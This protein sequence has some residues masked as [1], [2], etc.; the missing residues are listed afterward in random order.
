MPPR[1][2]IPS[3]SRS[4]N[5]P[6]CSW[7][8]G[9]ALGPS[10]YSRSASS[11]KKRS[12]KHHDPFALALARQRKAANVSRQQVLQEEREAALGDSVRGKPTPFT[13][14]LLNGQ[15]I[16]RITPAEPSENTSQSPGLNYF[17]S[18]D[19]LNATLERSEKLSRPVADTKSGSFDPQKLEDET[20]KHLDKH[21][22]AQEAVKRIMDLSN[23]SS[24]ERKLVNIQRCIETFG[25][26][27]TDTALAP[28]PTGAAN[29][30]ASQLPLSQPPCWSRYR[31]VGSSDRDFNYKDSDPG[32][33]SRKDVTQ[34]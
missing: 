33:E 27:N 16:P 11:K 22:T 24:K 15:V 18:E 9:L 5:G 21:K 3:C 28:K 31:L 6:L 8:S 30:S 1:I 23:A 2:P 26:H 12:K 25:R 20:Q 4:L 32:K 17:V 29:P 34:R 7:F 10:I 19:E 14:A 13:E